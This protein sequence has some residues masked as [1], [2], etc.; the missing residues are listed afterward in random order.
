MRCFHGNLVLNVG[1]TA[2]CYSFT[3]IISEDSSAFAF[4]P[5]CVKEMTDRW[6]W[7]KQS[8]ESNL[9]KTWHLEKWKGEAAGQ[10]QILGKEG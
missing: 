3:L 5:L 9:N 10:K 2:F 7:F 4:I 1:Q 6:N 8:R